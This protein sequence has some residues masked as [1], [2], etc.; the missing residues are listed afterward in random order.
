MKPRPKPVPSTVTADPVTQGQAGS[1]KQE[2]SAHIEDSK[3]HDKPE[4]CSRST[5]VR[6]LRKISRDLLNTI[7]VAAPQDKLA[8]FADA[9]AYDNPSI[10]SDDLWEEVLNPFLKDVL[11]WGVTA[12][13]D[14][15]I[16]RGTLGFD[17]VAGFVA[18]FV[19]NRSVDE[20][21][22]EGKLAHLVESAKKIMFVFFERNRI[23]TYLT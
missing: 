21:L 12:D 13:L 7:P 17:A 18:Y 10:A 5:F 3:L 15:D 9:A 4:Q 19:E 8:R 2:S 11:G 1:S 16:Q 14:L 22:F 6:E 20:V 23:M